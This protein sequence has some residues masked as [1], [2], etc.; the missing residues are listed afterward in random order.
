MNTKELQALGIKAD[1][2][3]PLATSVN[4]VTKKAI[5]IIGGVLLRLSV[6]D[7]RSGKVSHT[8][9]LCY[10]SNNVKGIY[11]S[12]DACKALQVISTTFPTAGDCS[13]MEVNLDRSS[14]C[15][16]TG[17]GENSEC[18]CPGGSLPPKSKPQLPCEHI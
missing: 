5:E 6:H 17:V 9:Q 4:T 12:E 7:E 1:S 11:L 3:F 15:E 10:V 14:K 18:K 2:I 8:R 13:A 16:N